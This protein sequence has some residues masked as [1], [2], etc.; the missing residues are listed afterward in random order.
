M[1]RGRKPSRDAK[2]KNIIVRFQEGEYNA[3]REYAKNMDT[4]FS[5]FVRDVVLGYLDSKNVPTSIAIDDPNQLTI[6]TGE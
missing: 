5:T 6:D 4:P 2:R 3:I 1:R